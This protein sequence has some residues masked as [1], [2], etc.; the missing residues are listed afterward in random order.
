LLALNATIE[1]ARAARRAGAAL[2][3]QAADH[4]RRIATLRQRDEGRL[5]PDCAARAGVV[6]FPA[7]TARGGQ[8][9][10]LCQQ[11]PNPHPHTWVRDGA[12]PPANA[13]PRIADGSLVAPD[14]VR[15]PALPPTNY[16]EVARPALRY[17][18]VHNPLHAFDF[19]PLYRPADSGGVITLEPSRVGAASYGVLVPQVDERSVGQFRWKPR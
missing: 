1:A 3:R 14:Q 15:L 18:G 12:G 11:Q 2:E 19:G 17:L 16:S 10:H 6:D 5:S 4:E 13:I 9:D 8:V 7:I